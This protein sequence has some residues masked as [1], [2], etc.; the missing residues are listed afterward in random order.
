MTSAG[1]RNA[2]ATNVSATWS[3]RR[4]LESVES[5]TSADE[6]ALWPCAANALSAASGVRTDWAGAVGLRASSASH[7][8]PRL[9]RITEQALGCLHRRHD[10]RGW[11][12]QGGKR[13]GPRALATDPSQSQ[14]SVVLERTLDSSHG[15]EKTDRVRR[16]MLA[17]RLD[18]GAAEEIKPAA[19]FGDQRPLDL[20]VSAKPC[21]RANQGGANELGLFGLTRAHR[22]RRPAVVESNQQ[23]ERLVPNNLIRIPVNGLRERRNDLG[24]RHA[25]QHPRGRYSRRI[26]E[27]RQALDGCLE[28][29]WAGLLRHDRDRRQQHDEDDM[30]QT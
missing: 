8:D 1:R 4:P 15:A 27:G 9:T 3:R 11:A 28:I 6:A 30:R 29:P 13:G 20:R 25:S 12:C 16:A 17:E 26:V 18:D 24:E 23:D 5:S 19:G 21:E 22:V 7:I 14:K 10:V 2:T